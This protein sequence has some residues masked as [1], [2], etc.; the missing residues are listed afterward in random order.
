VPV[1]DAE[2][3]QGTGYLHHRLRVPFWVAKLRVIID[4]ETV[5]GANYGSL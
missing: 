4:F 1:S 3:I 2:I 5:D